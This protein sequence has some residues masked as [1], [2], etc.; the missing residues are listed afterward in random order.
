[1]RRCHCIQAKN[2]STSQRRRI[3]VVV[4]DLACA[5][6]AIGAVRR[7]HLDAVVSRVIIEW[8]T[9]MGAVADKGLRLGFDHVEVEA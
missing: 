4:A 3:A 7:D 1:M 9:V 8:I 2:R 5:L 6:A